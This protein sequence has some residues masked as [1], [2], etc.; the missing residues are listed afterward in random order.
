[1][2]LTFAEICLLV[3]LGF[4][5]AWVFLQDRVLQVISGIGAILFVI[6]TLVKAIK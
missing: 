2:N 5:G 1:M 6:I 3:A 4:Y